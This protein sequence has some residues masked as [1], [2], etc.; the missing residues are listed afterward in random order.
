MKIA[1]NALKRQISYKMPPRFAFGSN[2][3]KEVEKNGKILQNKRS[4]S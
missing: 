1:I 4:R 3:Q 2:E